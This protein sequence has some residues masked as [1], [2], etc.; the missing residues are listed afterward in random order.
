MLFQI[1]HGLQLDIYGPI[2]LPIKE[3]YVNLI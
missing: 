2:N 1:N 3:A